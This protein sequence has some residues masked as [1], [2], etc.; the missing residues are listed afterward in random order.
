MRGDKEILFVFVI[1]TLPVLITCFCMPRAASFFDALPHHPHMLS[2]FRS[3]ASHYPFHR[4]IPHPID[5]PGM[6]S[7]RKKPS[8]IYVCLGEGTKSFLIPSF[9]VE[10]VNDYGGVDLVL[11]PCQTHPPL[12]GTKHAHP[13]SPA[14]L[15]S[16][17]DGPI[18]NDGFLK[19][20][21]LLFT[22]NLKVEFIYT[23]A[24]SN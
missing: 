9:K 17:R 5:D 24:I 1:V 4:H 19:F 10:R 7:K 12:D 11:T 22:C 8:H 2:L 18:S 21:C 13:P 3:G 16:S 20:G 23:H 15:V 6:V 14:P